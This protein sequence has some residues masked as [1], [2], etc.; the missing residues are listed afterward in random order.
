MKQTI[1]F[2]LL[3]IVVQSCQVYQDNVPVFVSFEKGTQSNSYYLAFVQDTTH[4]DIYYGFQIGMEKDT[5]QL[6]YSNQY[7]LKGANLYRFNG[8]NMIKTDSRA[9]TDGENEFVYRKAN[10]LDFTGGYHGDEQMLNINFYINNDS[11]LTLKKSFKLLPCKNFKYVQKSTLHAT[12][13]PDSIIDKNHAVEA[14]HY[15]TTIFNNSGYTTTNKIEWLQNLEINTI[16]GS[17]SCISR[18]FGGY[19]VSKSIDTVTFNTDGLYKLHSKDDCILL[20]NAANSNY[21]VIESDFSNFN[22]AATQY[23]WDH[24]AYNKY[25]RDTGN[26]RVKKGDIFTFKTK[27]LFAKNLAAPLSNFE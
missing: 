23:I 25:Y 19:G 13:S 18:D 17:L 12:A 26:M 16:Y 20:W 4:R 11:L 7:R 5:S 24:Q 21:A 6:G 22:D 10:T 3:L 2:C 27:V 15:K 14:I 9:L 8:Y 1:C